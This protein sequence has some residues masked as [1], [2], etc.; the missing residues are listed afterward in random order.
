MMISGTRHSVPRGLRPLWADAK[1]KIAALQASGKATP[2]QAEQWL[3]AT[4]TA[5]TTQMKACL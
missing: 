4:Q 5:L 2:A 1:A 3:A